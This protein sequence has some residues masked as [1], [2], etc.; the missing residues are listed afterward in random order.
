MLLFASAQIC[1]ARSRITDRHTRSHIS[2]LTLPSHRSS[3]L[4]SRVS[5]AQREAG[6]AA[7]LAGCRALEAD[8]LERELLAAKGELEARKA[9]SERLAVAIEDAQRQANNARS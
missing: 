7:R 1:G 5:V 4:S 3:Q 9:E 2:L 8:S 6:A